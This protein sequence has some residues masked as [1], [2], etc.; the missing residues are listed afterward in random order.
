MGA[1][2]DD[3]TRFDTELATFCMPVPTIVMGNGWKSNCCMERV[4]SDLYV[5][6][7]LG[8]KVI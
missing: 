2:L 1:N 5:H 4:S 7:A 8:R 6:L 3:F